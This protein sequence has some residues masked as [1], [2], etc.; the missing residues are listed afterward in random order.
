MMGVL[1][2]GS[3]SKMGVGE[4]EKLAWKK[5]RGGLGFSETEVMN[6]KIQ[7]KILKKEGA[8]HTVVGFL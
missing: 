7:I 1:E 6:D 2:E 3:S 4:A 5:K 8:D